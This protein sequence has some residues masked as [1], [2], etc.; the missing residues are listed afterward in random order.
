MLFQGEGGGIVEIKSQQRT[1]SINTQEVAK[2][3]DGV[4]IDDLGAMQQA[5]QDIVNQVRIFTV[6]QRTETMPTEFCNAMPSAMA[7]LN[8]RAPET[9]Y[10]WSRRSSNQHSPGG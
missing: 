3:L 5:A 9:V 10:V 7:C 4:H 6:E 2:V 1:M 8:V